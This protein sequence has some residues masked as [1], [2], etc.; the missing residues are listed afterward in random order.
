MKRSRPEN[1]E[2]LDR[3]GT[4]SNY[5]VPENFEGDFMG[6]S[7]GDFTAGNEPNPW[8]LSSPM[9]G[10]MQM[11]GQGPGVGYNGGQVSPGWGHQGYIG[12]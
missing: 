8:D 3:S 10:R 6:Y 9:H 5:H 4:R 2:E 11:R 12:G 1:F 7:F